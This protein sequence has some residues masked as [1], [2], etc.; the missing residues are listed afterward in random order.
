MDFKDKLIHKLLM[1][2]GWQ[3]KVCEL[4]FVFKI[5]EKKNSFDL[6]V[7][8]FIFLYLIMEWALNNNNPFAEKWRE[9]TFEKL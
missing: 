9:E 4:I 5:K 3:L 6:E 7:A 2:S 8:S 1:C